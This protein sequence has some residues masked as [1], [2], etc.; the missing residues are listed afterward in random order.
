MQLT[1]HLVLEKALYSALEP[2]DIFRENPDGTCYLDL[3][4]MIPA[5][6]VEYVEMCEQAEEENLFQNGTS[7]YYNLV[8]LQRIFESF[9]YDS[10]VSILT[11][12]H[13]NALY[14]LTGYRAVNEDVA[15]DI[16]ER[17]EKGQKVSSTDIRALNDYISYTNN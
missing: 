11:V 5:D 16:R 17:I 4:E 7:L 8:S 3:A 2:A 15:T 6:T 14:L 9:V 10:K 1:S 12:D 13:S